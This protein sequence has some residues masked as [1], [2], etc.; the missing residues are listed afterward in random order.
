ME[1]KI[2][3]NETLFVLK[4][5]LWV[6]GKLTIESKNLKTKIFMHKI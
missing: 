3:S 1:L 2:S 6:Y 5:Q 4:Q